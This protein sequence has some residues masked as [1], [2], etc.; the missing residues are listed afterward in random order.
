[1]QVPL[2]SDQFGINIDENIS[3]H[4]IIIVTIIDVIEMN[5]NPNVEKSH[6]PTN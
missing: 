5:E 6:S 4:L 1:M 2:L 3:L